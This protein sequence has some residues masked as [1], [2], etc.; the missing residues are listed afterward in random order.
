MTRIKE[1]LRQFDAL[2]ETIKEDFIVECILV[3][4][5][6]YF[7]FKEQI[8]AMNIQAIKRPK[9]KKK[10]SSGI[11]LCI[12]KAATSTLLQVYTNQTCG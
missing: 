4:L 7:F 5:S 2:S 6:I 12:E 9:W 3:W 10:R 8:Q 1:L 11:T